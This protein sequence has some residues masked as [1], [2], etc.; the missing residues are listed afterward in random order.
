MS[1][2]IQIASALSPRMM[3]LRHR[4][5]A[6]GMTRMLE[7]LKDGPFAVL[8][9]ATVN[10]DDR[11]LRMLL[12]EGGYGFVRLYG[13]FTFVGGAGNEVGEEAFFVPRITRQEAGALNRAC[14]WGDD[15][16]D[17]LR[18]LHPNKAVVKHH[19]RS[20]GMRDALQQVSVASSDRVW[21]YCYALSR[22]PIPV[23]APLYG[24]VTGR[25]LDP[26]TSHPAMCDALL[27]VTQLS[28]GS[29]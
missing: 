2:T 24:F 9:S 19:D 29:R 20:H 21:F 22:C 25:E 5:A 6:A 27:P 17:D 18:F 28:C 4:I 7:R 23:S 14:V 11:A 26:G 10:D 12:Y 15:V 13:L 1:R 16:R 3:R 8:P